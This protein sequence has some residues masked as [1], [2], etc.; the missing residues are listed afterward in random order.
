HLEC[1]LCIEAEGSHVPHES[2]R[3]T[4]A[5]FVPVTARAVGR[6][7]PSFITGQRLEPAFDDVPTLSTRSQ[8]FTRV[9][10]SSAHLTGCPAFSESLPTPAVVPEQHP[11]VWTPVL[12]PESEGPALIS[13]AARLLQGAITA[14]SLRLRGAR[15]SA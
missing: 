12:Q 7:L 9:R 13:R 8:R 1:S 2:L 6:R 4:H 14:S 11:V 3:W 15:S 10:L 5:V